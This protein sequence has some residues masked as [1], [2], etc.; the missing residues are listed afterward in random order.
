MKVNLHYELQYGNIFSGGIMKRL[1]QAQGRYKGTREKAIQFIISHPET[2]AF[3]SIE[4]LAQKIGISA[5]SLSRTSVDIGYSGFPEMQKDVQASLRQKLLPS[6]RMEEAIPPDRPFNFRDSI[7]KDI[8]SLEDI[9]ITI[10]DAK[11]QN[12]VDSISQAQEV[13]VVG[14][15]TQYPSAIYLQCIL[16]QIQDRVTLITQRSHIACFSRMS[17]KDLLFSICLPRYSAFTVRSV[18][19]ASKK[20]IPI[21]AVTDNE[22]SPSG[23]LADI[24]LQV[25]FESMSFFN[26]NVAVMAILNALTTAIA[27]THRDS[28]RNKIRLLS[29]VATNWGVFYTTNSTE[30]HNQ[31]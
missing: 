15:G 13:F 5:S 12:A 24:V 10:T 19:E 9:L 28:T 17:S 26:S 16:E 11:F 21:I 25:N 30:G 29:D 1:K 6:V 23:K 20:G 3:L 31:P 14:L 22:L 7:R 8:R 2:A 18:Q 4:A 27:L